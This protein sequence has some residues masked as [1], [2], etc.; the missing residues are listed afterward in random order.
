MGIAWNVFHPLK[1]PTNTPFIW[2]S[3]TLRLTTFPFLLLKVF[4]CLHPYVKNTSKHA[5]VLVY[6]IIKLFYICSI[7]LPYC[8]LYI[9]VTAVQFVFFIVICVTNYYRDSLH[10][11]FLIPPKVDGWTEIQQDLEKHAGSQWFTVIFIFLGHFI[12]TN[13]F[14]GIIIMASTVLVLKKWIFKFIKNRRVTRVHD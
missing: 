10:V 11:V 8:F 9:L 12:F 5:E 4:L 3:I 7:Y 2:E 14:I 13:L 1:V 6:G